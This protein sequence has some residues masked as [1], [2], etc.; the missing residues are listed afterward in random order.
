MVTQAKW[1]DLVFDLNIPM[2]RYPALVERLAGTPT[3]LE[4]KMRNTPF[5]L[6]TQPYNNGWSIQQHAGHLLDL[7]ELI[8]H[9]LD[10]FET[11][12]E[13]LTAADMTNLKTNTAGHNERDINIIL[14]E[15]RTSRMAIVKRMKQYDEAMVRHTVFHPRLQM[16]MSIAGLAYFFAEHDDHHLATISIIE[17][18]LE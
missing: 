15:F 16:P 8:L 18:A 10:D 3:R 11:G 2:G 6:L 12:K 5:L 17:K 9:R 13:V 7:E 1:T 14:K 4:E